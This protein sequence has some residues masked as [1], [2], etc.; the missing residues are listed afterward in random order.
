[1]TSIPLVTQITNAPIRFVPLGRV[2]TNDQT[3]G[4]TSMELGLA[5]W[6]QILDSFDFIFIMF[7]LSLL[8]LKLV[9][10]MF[11]LVAFLSL[12]SA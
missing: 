10:C 11:I 7:I 12:Q 5:G 8:C 9:T 2:S 6:L 3:T 4:P 1:L